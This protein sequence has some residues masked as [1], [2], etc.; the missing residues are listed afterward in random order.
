MAERTE[1]EKAHHGGRGISGH[2]LDDLLDYGDGKDD[3]ENLGSI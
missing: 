1:A 3:T 2:G